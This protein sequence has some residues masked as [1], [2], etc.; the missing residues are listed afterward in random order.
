MEASNDRKERIKK[1]QVQK[2]IKEGKR[3]KETKRRYKVVNR[4]RR[5]QEESAEREEDEKKRGKK[6]KDFT[7]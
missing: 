7:R 6:E 5:R 4:R 2:R 3:D 1:T